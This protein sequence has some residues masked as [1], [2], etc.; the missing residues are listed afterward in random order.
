MKVSMVM[1][2]YNGEEYLG[3]AIN[4]I[5]AQTY[6]ELEIIIVN[7][8]ST[9]STAKILEEINDVRVKIIHLATNKGAANAL[10]VGIEQAGG[11]WI[12]IHD[13]DDISLPYRIEE[14]VAYL[15]GKQKVVAV[16]SFIEC[17]AGNNI[18]EAMFAYMKNVERYKNS[19]ITWQQY[20][21]DLLKGCPHTHGS[22]LISKEALLRAGKYD[23][24][25]KIAYDYDMLMRVSGIG[26]IENVPKVLYKY[27]LSSNSLS[28]K[29][30]QDTSREFLSVATTYIQYYRFNHKKNNTNV[31]VYGS[32]KGCEAFKE[33]MLREKNFIVHETISDYKVDKIKRAIIDYKKGKVDAFIILDNAPEENNMIKLLSEKGLKLNKNYFT[34][35]SFI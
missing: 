17:I 35:W 34:L 10:N 23:P 5:L 2:V 14:Q 18:S 9:D 29:D 11:D 19:I 6:Q 31:I 30:I 1:A 27:R 8:C 7:D 4:S 13:A 16:G 33:L 12:A 32:L 3:E 28:N 25:Y 21:E 15:Q 20:R 24:K 26:H 22:L